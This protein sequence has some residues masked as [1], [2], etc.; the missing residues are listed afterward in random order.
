MTHVRLLGPHD[1]KQ[2]VDLLYEAGSHAA[3]GSGL[4]LDGQ[5]VSRA[6]TASISRPE[7]CPCF[8][9]EDGDILTGVLFGV[10]V[11]TWFKDERWFE[12]K[13]FYI[14]PKY[15]TYPL[16]RAYVG[17]LEEWCREN[18]IRCIEVS[19][20]SSR[21]PRLDRLYKRLGYSHVNT[22]HAKRL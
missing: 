19:N 1:V 8:V 13:L 18:G 21:D 6:M 3:Y 4:Q 20:A 22:V 12:E 16:A 14:R 7:Y 9:H 17:A 5:I 10:V 15:R 11:D 2:A